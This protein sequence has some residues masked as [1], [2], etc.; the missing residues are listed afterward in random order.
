MVL[1]FEFL[2]CGKLLSPSSACQVC[3]D[4]RGEAEH[5]EAESTDACGAVQGWAG[6]MT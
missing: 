1:R 5:A 6:N 2:V 4:N 3:K